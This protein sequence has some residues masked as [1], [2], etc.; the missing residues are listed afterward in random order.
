[1]GTSETSQI[2]IMCTFWISTTVEFT[3]KT[4]VPKLPS[5]AAWSSNISLKTMNISIKLKSKYLS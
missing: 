1:M 3:P 4:N 2:M 5:D